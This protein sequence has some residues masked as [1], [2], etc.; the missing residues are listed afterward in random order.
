[1]P[2]PMQITRFIH[3]P[4]FVIEAQHFPTLSEVH[5]Q[6]S[7]GIPHIF[8][9]ELTELIGCYVSLAKKHIKRD[10]L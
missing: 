4:A 9:M 8:P 10:F 1:M 5:D 6:K 3:Y 7:I 2:L